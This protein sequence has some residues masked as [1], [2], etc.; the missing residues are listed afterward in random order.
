MALMVVWIHGDIKAQ[1]GEALSLAP[2]DCIRDA[3]QIAVKN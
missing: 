3:L 2:A 1:I